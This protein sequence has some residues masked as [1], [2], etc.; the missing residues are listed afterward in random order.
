MMPKSRPKSN[1]E[2]A[3]RPKIWCPLIF[4]LKSDGIWGI[5]KQEPPKYSMYQRLRDVTTRKA[6]SSKIWNTEAGY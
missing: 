2:S 5:F 3:V 6:V 4:S 1:W